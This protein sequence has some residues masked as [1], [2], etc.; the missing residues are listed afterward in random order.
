MKHIDLVVVLGLFATVA[1]LLF[2]EVPDANR[3][4]VN[5]IVGGLLG[6][7]ARNYVNHGKF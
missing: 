7:L 4:M 6:F 1:A 5:I 3:D 2:N